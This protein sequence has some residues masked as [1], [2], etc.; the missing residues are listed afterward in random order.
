MMKVSYYRGSFTIRDLFLS[1][2]SVVGRRKETKR[3]LFFM[4][5]SNI[6][7]M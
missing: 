7:T 2:T 5:N 3:L 4:K 1:M 6:T